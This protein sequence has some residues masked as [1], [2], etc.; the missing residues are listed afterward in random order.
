MTLVGSIFEIGVGVGI[1]VAAAYAHELTHAAVGKALGGRLLAVDV[2]GLEVVMEM[3][4]ERT[5]SA[6][7]LAPGIVGVAVVPLVVAVWA[8]SASLM[9]KGAV[10]LAW[11]VYTLAGGTEGELTLANPKPQ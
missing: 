2:I 4:S 10:S 6:M 9:I 11:G 7:L 5:N 3:P 8:S 1:I